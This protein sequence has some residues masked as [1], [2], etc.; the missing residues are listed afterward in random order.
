EV[1]W[2][3]GYEG[4]R[5][6]R[7]GN[8]AHGQRQLDVYGEV[9]DALFQARQFGLAP[10]SDGWRVGRKL[11]E[12]LAAH[13]HE[14]GD[15]IWEVRGARQQFTHSKVMAWVAFDRAVRAVEQYGLDLPEVDDWRKT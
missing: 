6:V 11:L 2:L 12:W 10:L 5:P 3:P 14:P 15:G 1:P 7:V 8:A 4:S 9:S 13:W